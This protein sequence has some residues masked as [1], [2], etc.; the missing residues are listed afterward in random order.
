VVMQMSVY[1]GFPAA[2]NGLAAIKEV[3]EMKAIELPLA[4]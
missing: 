1:A 4:E 3:F 2:L